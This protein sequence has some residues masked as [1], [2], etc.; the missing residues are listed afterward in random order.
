M[1]GLAQKKLA[2]LQPDIGLAAASP[3]HSIWVNASAGTGKTNILTRRVLS[4]L[5]HGIRAEKIICL[6]YTKAAAA[7]MSSRIRSQLADWI[8]AADDLLYQKIVKIVGTEPVDDAMLRRARYL[9]AECL[10]TPDGLKIQ[11]IHGFCQSILQRFPLE[12][13]LLPRFKVCEERESKLLLNR[14]LR[15]V[16][17]SQ[18][19]PEYLQK[20][21][22]MLSQILGQEDQ[23]SKLLDK[24]ISKRQWLDACFDAH[25]GITDM[26]GRAAELLGI[27]QTIDRHDF[28]TRACADDVFS[29]AELRRAGGI[30][31][32][33]TTTEINRAEKMLPWLSLDQTARA[34]CWNNYLDAFLTG[35]DGIYKTL[36]TKGTLEK[37]PDLESILRT[38]AERVLRIEHKLK[39]YD[40]VDHTESALQ[41]AHAVLLKYQDIKSKQ[42]VLDYDDLIACTLRLLQKPGI[43]PWVLFKLDGGIDHVLIDEAQDTSPEQWAIIKILTGEFFAGDGTRSN[44]ASVFAVGDPKQSIFSFQ[45]ADPRG[46]I[47]MQGYYSSAAFESRQEL[48][49]IPLTHSY[50]SAG[51]V[52]QVVDSVFSKTDAKRG[53][54]FFTKAEEQKKLLLAPDQELMEHI[55]MR[56]DISGL[57]EIWP[58]ALDSEKPEITPWRTPESRQDKISG[59]S[60]LADAIADRIQKWLENGEMLPA[61]SYTKRGARRMRA[62]DIMILVRRRNAFVGTLT[63]ALKMR[64]IPVAGVDRLVLSQHI[65]IMDLLAVGKFLLLPHDD[66]NLCSVLKSPLCGINPDKI[67]NLLFLLCHNRKEKS[68]WQ[69]LREESANPDLQ[70]AYNFLM[71]IISDHQSSRPFEIYSDILNKWNGRKKFLSRLGIECLDPLDEF[72]NLCAANN[73]RTSNLQSFVHWMESDKTEVKRDLDAGERSEVRIMTVHAS[74]GLQAPIVFLPDTT[75]IPKPQGKSPDLMF[76]EDKKILLWPG[77][78]SWIVDYAQDLRQSADQKMHEEY[79]RLLYVALTRAED[80]LYIAGYGEAEASSWYS[81]IAQSAF[82]LMQIGQAESVNFDFGAH[83]SESWQGNG[84]RIGTAE[85]KTIPGET[86]PPEIAAFIKPVSDQSWLIQPPPAE[87]SPPKPLNPSRPQIPDPAVLSPILA[88]NTGS[89]Q[90]AGLMRGTMMHRILQIVPNLAP[91]KRASAIDNY[92]GR[93]HAFIGDA[94]RANII[95]QILG[96]LKN[97]DFKDYFSSQSKAEVPITGIAG[98]Q[99]ISGQIDRLFVGENIVKILDFKTGRRT[100]ESINDVP[101]AYLKQVA[102]Y[103]RLIGDIYPQKQVET[104]LLWTEDAKLMILPPSLLDAHKP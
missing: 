4:L 13:G 88:A 66:L 31:A 14:A 61:N 22:A 91:D 94:D 55:A 69:R 56:A 27:D 96:L 48:R 40:L 51:E 75:R 72:L 58:L 2:G 78:N 79:R 16:I 15:D 64:G 54:S 21:M 102:A 1:T 95:T 60:R 103:A 9:F 45:H 30:L 90:H 18:T 49:I 29:V 25:G 76:D 28:L 83:I 57:V 39:A 59:Q 24:I 65:A 11:T 89:K 77:K 74:K 52:L 50:R 67:E 93:F 53:V 98:G 101:I 19:K 6:T 41:L 44:P 34:N 26:I 43:A 38:E 8:T 97:P 84:W 12:A 10:D 36:V 70:D 46:F 20:S 87:P 42:S 32:T 35:D 81:F 73:D 37:H 17:G 82:D 71:Q 68:V 7:E 86:P 3:G 5:L 104:A 62:G 100:P 33:G 92:I 99:V 23:L 47:E 63:R 80:R 85:T